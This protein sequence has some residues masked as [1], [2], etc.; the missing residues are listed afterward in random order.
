MICRNLRSCASATLQ[1]QWNKTWNVFYHCTF[2]TGKQNV[3]K[4]WCAC[5]AVR[6][7]CC[8]NCLSLGHNFWYMEN[9]IRVQVIFIDKFNDLDRS[10]K[11][12]SK[13]SKIFICSQK[14]FRSMSWRSHFRIMQKGCSVLFKSRL[15]AILIDGHLSI[16]YSLDHF[17][18]VCST[19]THHTQG[20]K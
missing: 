16:G 5:I 15:Q 19:R 13:I 18:H 11:N 6:K 3:A 20:S 1:W 14:Q 4:V 12:T 7:F 17:I 2:V 10:N 8:H 9:I